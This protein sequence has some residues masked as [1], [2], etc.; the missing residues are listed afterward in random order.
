MQKHST[1]KNA[2]GFT[3]IELLIVIAIIGILSAIAIPQF[4]QYKIRGYDAHSK[5][6]LKDM[7][8][9]C[10]AYWLD[11]DALQGCDLPKIKEVT[12]GFN[13]NTDVVATL[14]PSPLNNFC[15]S[16][17][18]NSSPNTY[19]IDSAALISEGGNCSGAGGSVQ[20][21]S[22]SPAQTF[23]TYKETQFIDDCNRNIGSRKNPDGS[24]VEGYFA[25][26]ASD[27]SVIH[28]GMFGISYI[29]G[30]PCSSAVQ[31][32]PIPRNM[33]DN[34]TVCCKNCSTSSQGTGRLTAE[35]IECKMVF[36]G[37]ADQM[38]GRVISTGHSVPTEEW[39]HMQHNTSMLQ[40]NF[41]TGV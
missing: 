10:N 16:A 24:P 6:A 9:L 35:E 39:P 2:K 7:H 11:T 34:G 28:A 19:S 22:V 25:A 32:D 31:W 40:Y 3:L 36:V 17:K 12:Y 20:T 8:L 14:P 18:H 15:A 38:E 27:G 29:I 1:H 33:W 41:E 26:V 5:Q 21:A 23:A 37:A 13:Q 30:V 4:N